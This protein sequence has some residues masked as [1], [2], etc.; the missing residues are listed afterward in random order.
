MRATLPL[1]T[2]AIALIASSS[3][4]ASKQAL[5]EKEAALAACEEER[6]A[7]ARS[8]ERWQERFDR[9]SERWQGMQQAI[10]EAV[11]NALAEIDAERERILELVPEQVQFE[12]ATLLEDYFDV[13]GQSFAAVRRDNETIRLQLE[14]TQKALAAVGKDTQAINAAIEG[15]VAEAQQRLDAEQEQRRILAG[16]L[17]Q[18]VARLVEFDRRKLSCKDCPDRIKLSRKER[19]AILA[20]HGE[21]LRELSAL[22]K[23]AGPP[24]TPAAAD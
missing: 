14:A 17:A 2:L 7:L 23:Q 22:Q 8:V 5:E 21:L 13:V 6:A 4:C 24:A 10:N 3:G 16:G 11:P 19:E 1:L 18:L 12:V 9:A 20:F 15:A